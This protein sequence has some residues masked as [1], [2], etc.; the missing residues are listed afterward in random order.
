MLGIVAKAQWETRNGDAIAHIYILGEEV[1][2]RDARQ[3]CSLQ[4]KETKLIKLPIT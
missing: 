2:E 3:T 1:L 4:I